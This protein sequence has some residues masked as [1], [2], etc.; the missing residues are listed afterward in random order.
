M[1]TMMLTKCKVL[2]VLLLLLMVYGCSSNKKP[3][4]W[5]TIVRVI[6]GVGR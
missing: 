5:T 1:M 4:P 6:T 3:T 2:I